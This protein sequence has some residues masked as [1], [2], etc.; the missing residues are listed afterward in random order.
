MGYLQLPSH[1]TFGLVAGRAVFLDLKRDRYVALPPPAEEVFSRLRALD[2]PLIPEGPE[3]DLLL[4]TGLFREGSLRGGLA[5]A[6]A[7]APSGS[8]FDDEAGRA[9]AG[10][11]A[12]LRARS[13][14][15]R[16]RKRLVERTL[17]EI[18]DTIRESRYGA[19]SPGD[20]AAAEV[21]A[22]VFLAARAMVPTERRCLLDC[23]AMM[24]WLGDEARHATLVFGVRLDPFAAH[25]W[26]QTD[27]VLLTDA[28]DTVGMFVPVL[29]V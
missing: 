2:E 27:R 26:L 1:I 24:D 9:R 20:A 17:F 28:A 23:L 10:L 11:A 7:P 21:A 14:V 29:S 15:S 19:S 6:A 16:A 18:V 5:P 25:C 13:A 22:G 8:L 12:W 4:G 3:R